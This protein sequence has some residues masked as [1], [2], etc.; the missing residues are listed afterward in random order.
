MLSIMWFKQFQCR[1]CHVPVNHLN[2]LA[3]V[4]PIHVYENSS[5]LFQIMT[6]YLVVPQWRVASRHQAL[7]W[8]NIDLPS[9]G[10]HNEHDEVSNHRRFECS[11]NR[12]SR[13]RSKKTSKF[14]VIGLCKGDSPVTGE[15]AA[16]R[17]SN[18]ENVFIWWRHHESFG[19]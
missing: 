8:T 13:R 3:S 18:A 6:C 10:R 11:T 5:A 4:G 15:Y 2:Q 1:R 16:Q 12:L 7:T 17:A 19:H 14:R 9:V